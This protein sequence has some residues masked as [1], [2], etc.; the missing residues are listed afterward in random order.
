LAFEE[1]TDTSLPQMA[2]AIGAGIGLWQ[3]GVKFEDPWVYRRR[4]NPGG[5]R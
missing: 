1:E 4:E 5:Q 2:Q 3:P